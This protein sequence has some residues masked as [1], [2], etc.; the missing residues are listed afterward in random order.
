MSPLS[1]S[2]ID[3]HSHL[4]H[5]H[6]YSVAIFLSSAFLS[7]ITFAHNSA[8]NAFVALGGAV[9]VAETSECV[10][11]NCTFSSNSV[12][13]IVAAGGAL[14]AIQQSRLIVRSSTFADSA[15]T[16]RGYCARGL[17]DAV[18]RCPVS[19]GGAIAVSASDV[20]LVDTTLISSTATCING[21]HNCT[22][23][24]AAVAVLQDAR[25]AITGSTC[26]LNRL[27]CPEASHCNLGDG[28]CLYIDSSVV[29]LNTSRVRNNTVD[30]IGGGG[31]VFGAGSCVLRLSQSDISGNTAREGGGVL[32]KG[33]S[34]ASIVECTLRENTATVA[35][36]LAAAEDAS[37]TIAGSSVA[38]NTGAR[39]SGI[40][41]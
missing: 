15:A 9:L 17:A 20:E 21:L 5:T 13:A 26:E 19:F 36:A 30:G 11:T 2:L 8:A 4:T 27:A 1:I 10:V 35:G 23:H 12:S 6:T 41:A 37:F 29:E 38:N 39:L 16:A 18:T 34:V 31:G 33:S 25:L 28:G 24:G 14:A 7:S 32:L 40:F 22:S 3:L